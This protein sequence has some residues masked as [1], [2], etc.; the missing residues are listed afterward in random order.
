[1]IHTCHARDSH[2]RALDSQLDSHFLAGGNPRLGTCRPRLR[3]PRLDF[4][5]APSTSQAP[6]VRSPSSPVPLDSA[7][8]DFGRHAQTSQAPER[9]T[10]RDWP[11]PTS[12]PRLAIP[13]SPLESLPSRLSSLAVTCTLR[14]SALALWPQIATIAT[15]RLSQAP[16]IS[17]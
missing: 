9:H 1:L 14:H 17:H 12:L 3:S 5:S 6:A 11:C 8:L 7:S 16:G 13:A 2:F 15:P 4:A 10:K